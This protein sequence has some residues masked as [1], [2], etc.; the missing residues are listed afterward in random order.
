M[1]LL[2]GKVN[3]DVVVKEEVLGATNVVKSEHDIMVGHAETSMVN[4][5]S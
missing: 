4:L 1:D 5:S 3:N 2:V